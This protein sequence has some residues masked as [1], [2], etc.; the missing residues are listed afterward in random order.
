MSRQKN[1]VV[2]FRESK[3]VAADLA[4][5]VITS[6][7]VL[8]AA[9]RFTDNNNSIWR[10]VA[11]GFSGII[12][13]W[14]RSQNEVGGRQRSIGEASR[15]YLVP[16]AMLIYMLLTKMVA[17]SDIRDVIEKH[18]E[19]IAFIFSFSLISFGMGRSHLFE[20]Y[21]WKIARKSDGQ[22]NKLILYLFILSSALTLV[23]SNDIVVFIMTPIVLNI[24]FRTKIKNA[25]L[26]ILS[27]FVAANIAAVGL[28]FGSPTNLILGRSV[29]W[30]FV[31]YLLVMLPTTILT[32]M[33]VFSLIQIINS[34]NE[35]DKRNSLIPRI[36]GNS[37]A[38]WV[39]KIVRG[40]P[41]NRGVFRNSA[42]VYDSRLVLSEGHQ[43]L[44]KSAAMTR[45]S[46]IF[47]I[48]L[49]VTISVTF[50]STTSLWFAVI[51]I[52]I[53]AC[54][55]FLLDSQHAAKDLKT[56][57]NVKTQSIEPMSRGMTT[58]ESL[59]RHLPWE[60]LIFALAFFTLCSGLVQSPEFSNRIYPATQEVVSKS[61]LIGSVGVGAATTVLSSVMNDL[62]AA[63]LS[64]EIVEYGDKS[65]QQLFSSDFDQVSFV[66]NSILGLNLGTFIT[67]FGAL[68]GLIWFSTLRKNRAQLVKRY[69]DRDI[70]LPRPK[71]LFRYGSLIAFP[72]IVI[73][74]IANYGIVS[75]AHLMLLPFDLSTVGSEITFSMIAG[76]V[77]VVAI[78][79]TFR[80][81]LAKSDVTLVYIAQLLSV[82]NRV[83]WF[84]ERH[85]LTFVALC[86]TLALT[87]V[88]G[89][90]YF[91]ERLS[92]RMCASGQFGTTCD[93]SDS[94]QRVQSLPT[95]VRQFVTWTLVFM[96]SQFEQDRFPQSL[97]GAIL[98]GG[99]AIGGLAIVVL[100]IRT[101]WR[102]RD[103]SLRA[104]YAMGHSPGNRTILVN[105]E[106]DQPSILL[107]KGKVHDLS[108]SSRT[109]S[110]SGSHSKSNGRHDS[111]KSSRIDLGQDTFFVIFGSKG[112]DR[113]E[114]FIDDRIPQQSFYIPHT[115]RVSEIVA[116]YNFSKANE[117]FLFSRSRDQDLQNISILREIEA[118]FKRGDKNPDLQLIV[119][120]HNKAVEKHIKT[121]CPTIIK[122]MVLISVEDPVVGFVE[123]LLIPSNSDQL[124]KVP[125]NESGESLRATLPSFSFRNGQPLI[126]Q[127]E[128]VFV[129]NGGHLAETLLIKLLEKL[130]PERVTHIVPKGYDYSLPALLEKL[131]D[132]VLKDQ[133]TRE[134]GSD[135][136]R[137]EFIERGMIRGRDQRFI[138]SVETSEASS[139]CF[140]AERLLEEVHAEFIN[141]EDS[142]RKF[143]VHVSQ[144]T[145]SELEHRRFLGSS[146]I[147]AS[148]TQKSFQLSFVKSYL[149]LKYGVHHEKIAEDPIE[150]IVKLSGDIAT[151]A[152]N[153]DVTHAGYQPKWSGSD[154]F[155]SFVGR[156]VEAVREN[157]HKE[158]G[159]VIAESKDRDKEEGSVVAVARLQFH[160]SDR[161][162]ALRI[163]EDGA[164][165][166]EM[167]DL[168]IRS[169]LPGIEIKHHKT[170]I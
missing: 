164:D 129:I 21:A 3:R 106:E 35:S 148:V 24:A 84:A 107:H 23:T 59:L 97:F 65:N 160:A 51:P 64:G 27:Q 100:I 6:L 19:I 114:A 33:L 151:W 99:L 44:S 145:D 80:R 110:H 28:I 69:P 39:K 73:L 138:V 136:E 5:S 37:E 134:L 109:A 38:E 49:L 10:F 15:V 17:W 12:W 93:I 11:V 78:F 48:A 79:M 83:R 126:K 156:T 155:V 43:H 89:T 67:P 166:I 62:P 50:L 103:K 158:E 152:S 77:T 76:L 146:V 137:Y 130:G 133:I 98:A 123:E 36:L 154:Q 29:Q 132:P 41:R 159:S 34:R 127:D 121:L 101:T 57:P 81:Q 63:S 139:R 96:T 56:D 144:S 95:G 2:K 141:Q 115:N 4:T 142:L 91:T 53:V 8:I 117:I 120:I 82:F 74:G 169:P 163:F 147:N 104:R 167:D 143:G 45:W 125:T 61:S 1:T 162:V 26:L 22:T 170:D 14:P 42:W 7:V 9:F 60:I 94:M 135:E 157:S 149:W 118:I 71:D 108:S 88:S 140:S 122:N 13:I 25:R 168:I 18:A 113:L 20:Y 47:G 58:S 86:S 70:D 92:A 124:V 66:Q 31:Q 85:R 131:R 68:A 55:G 46:R 40:L 153:F 119:Q 30:G 52:S 32:I 128:K 112:A 150:K 105:V 16:L 90:L 54:L 116:E 75:L 165:E 102:G 161:T 72:A 87:V 111:V